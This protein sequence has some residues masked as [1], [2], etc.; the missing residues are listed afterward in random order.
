MAVPRHT[1]KAEKSR[2]VSMTMPQVYQKLTSKSW[3]SPGSCFWSTSFL[4][5]Q[6]IPLRKRS[7]PDLFTTLW[8]YNSAPDITGILPCRSKVFSEIK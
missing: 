2:R 6:F 7:S 1:R 3:L 4:L 5:S 8:P